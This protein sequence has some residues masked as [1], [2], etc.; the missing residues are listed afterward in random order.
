MKKLIALTLATVM[1][2]AL[3]AC[4]G[5]STG[6]NSEVSYDIP[7]GK[8]L[9]NDAVIDVTLS[10]HASW[11]YDENWKVWE[12]IEEAV[13]G[14]IN[15]NAVPSSDF[16]TKFS[17]TMAAPDSLPDIFGCQ[18]KPGSFADYCEQ[19]AFLALD[20][21]EEFLPDYNKFWDSLPEDEQWMRETRRS[22]DGKI[23]YAPVYGLE[24]STNIRGWLYRK[25]IFVQ[26]GLDVPQTWD[27]VEDII[28]AL[29]E[30]QLEMGLAQSMTQIRMYQT[31][32]EWFKSSYD[33]EYED[34]DS[35]DIDYNDRQFLRTIG[36]ETN[37]G[38]NE[39]LA[40]AHA[41]EQKQRHHLGGDGEKI[42]KHT[43]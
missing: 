25:D 6:G 2:L 21:Y 31:G 22:Y 30:N 17:L 5:E 43:Q 14:T 24:R 26:L 20:D 19:G 16:T 1:L 12:Y 27:D 29:S 38:S 32:E 36:I 9:P 23:Y 8:V 41:H 11:P 18:N 42:L 34:Y 7:E 37:L 4:G 10:S 28:R 39:A 33:Y 35:N 3:C 15:V 40:H 13:G